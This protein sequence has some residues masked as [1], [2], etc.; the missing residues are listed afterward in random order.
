MRKRNYLTMAALIA[1]VL[2]TICLQSASNAVPAFA[3]RAGGIGCAGC[4]WHQNALNATGKAFLRHGLR[5]ADEEA[6]ANKADLKLS[7]YASVVLAPSFSAVEND[8]TRFS[9]GDAMLWLGGAIDSK[10]SALAETEFHVDDEEVEVEEVYAHYVSDLGGKYLSARVGQFQ[11]L[12]FLTQV[13]G[14]ARTTLSRPEAISGRATN[15][16]SF[17][18]RDR[19]RGFELG[20][21]N[22]P[23]SA[24]LGIGNGPGQNASDNHMDIYTAIEREFGAQGSSVGAWAYW[25]KAVLAG[26][27]RDSFS[28]YGVIGNYTAVKTRVSAHYS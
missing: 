8:G 6:N 4:H 9:A 2:A 10:F 27:S 26:G 21:V 17:R 5:L 3:R 12:V 28:R 25:G 23:L 20:T 22:G 7:N 1:A 18:P 16:N 11:P 14:P 13:S 15:G 24:Y 19:V